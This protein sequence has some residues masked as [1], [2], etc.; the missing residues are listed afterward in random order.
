MMSLFG[1]VFKNII[2]VNKHNKTEVIAK[3]SKQNWAGISSD[4]P[5]SG[6]IIGKKIYFTPTKAH[7]SPL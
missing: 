7:L 3:D 1:Y 5:T 6:I 2:V 4:F